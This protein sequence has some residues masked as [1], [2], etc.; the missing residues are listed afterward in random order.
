M[1]TISLLA[2]AALLAFAFAPA[3]AQ[4]AGS[5]T[6]DNN[7]KCWEAAKNEV[8]DRPAG[9]KNVPSTTGSGSSSTPMSASPSVANPSVS[10]DKA[11]ERP[12]EAAGLPIC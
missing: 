5:T 7:F 11:P 6:G 4:S 8:R 3:G 1:K 10:I 2:G 12:K 9:T